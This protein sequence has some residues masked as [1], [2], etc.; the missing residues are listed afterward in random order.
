M[1]SFNKVIFMGHV[2][3]DPQLKYT[4]SQTAVVEFGLAANRK[5]KVQEEQREE[6]CFVDCAAFGKAAET[7]NQ[8]VKKGKPLLVEGRL[9]F[10]TWEDKQNGSKRSKLSIVVDSFQFIGGNGEA[11]DDGVPF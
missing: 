2:T 5:F 4:P 11:A 3:R 6:V 9:K 8:Y 1:A 7:I 10:D